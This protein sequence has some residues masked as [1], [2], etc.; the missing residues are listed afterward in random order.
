MG[1]VDVTRHYVDWPNLDPHFHELAEMTEKRLMSVVQACFYHVY[2]NPAFTV[3]AT[4]DVPEEVFLVQANRACSLWNQ[5]LSR[6]L[7]C[8][9][10]NRAAKKARRTGVTSASSGILV[11]HKKMVHTKRLSQPASAI[12]Q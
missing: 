12:K 10:R 3:Q 9:A 4:A 1:S 8:G 6:F 2:L 7:G 5:Q 11:L